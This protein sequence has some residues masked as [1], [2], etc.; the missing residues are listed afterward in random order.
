ME[1]SVFKSILGDLVSFAD[2]YAR[3]FGQPRLKKHAVAYLR[4]LLGPSDRKSVEPMALEEEF[5]VRTLQHFIG[6]ARWRDERVLKEHQRH[7]SETL[8][9]AGGVI[10][11]DGSSFPKQGGHSVGVARQ[12]CGNRGKEENCQVGVFL[13]YATERGHT[14]L[15][16]R[17]YLPKSWTQ[18]VRRRRECHVPDVVEFKTGWELAWEMYQ[19][20]RRA[21]VPHAWVTGDEEFGRVHALADFLHAQGQAYVFEV[22]GDTSVYTR[23]PHYRKARQRFSTGHPSQK[24]RLVGG[25]RPPVDVR[26]VFG[27]IPPRQWTRYR[28]RD[29][30]KGPLEVDAV[31]IQIWLSRDLMPGRPAWLLITR[32]R[33]PDP[34]VKYFLAEASWR[35][36]MP[37]FLRAAFSR[38]SIEQCFLQG[39]QELGMDQYETRS[40]AGWH[41]HM[42]MVLL[43]HHFLV[44]EREKR[45]EKGGR[46]YRRGDRPGPASG[47]GAGGR[48]AGAVMSKDPLSD[49]GA[50]AGSP[51]PLSRST[52]KGSEAGGGELGLTV[53][54]VA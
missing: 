46:T 3:L 10:V 48:A 36:A 4:G 52:Q 41:H 21:G 13:G 6:Q 49:P 43:A 8:G 17:L 34:E 35:L 32:G 20:A 42:T 12:W 11:F 25:A 50:P 7:V 2:R 44:L 27:K 1:P 16:R 33:G 26:E 54:N 28:I 31:R 24:P 38:W 45:G 39:K 5:N 51:I 47:A 40:W 29:G 37:E 22:P 53:P 18:D 14:L 15:D 19:E 9:R 30:E 23:P